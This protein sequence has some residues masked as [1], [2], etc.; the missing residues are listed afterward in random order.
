ME[1]IIIVMLLGASLVALLLV[2]FARREAAAERESAHREAE[3][4]RSEARAAIADAARREQQVVER[5]KEIAADHRNAQAYA[6]GLDERVEVIAR[7]EK[8]LMR[9]RSALDAERNR[10]R[11]EHAQEMAQLTETDPEALR[12]ELRAQLL[13]QARD[14]AQTELRRLERKSESEATSR[15][16]EIL[17]DAMQRQ[18]GETTTH[19]TTTWI[20]LPNEEMKG[21]IIGREGRNIRAF[22]SLTGVNLILEENVEAVQLSSFDVQRREIAEVALRA[23]IEDG[24]IQPQRIEAA[25]SR[26]LVGS[27]QRHRQAGLDALDEAGVKGLPMP[28]VD[29]LGRLRLRT[30]FGQTILGHLVESAQLAATLAAQVGADV[31][32]ARRAAFLH[33]IGKAFTPERKGPHAQIGAEFLAEHGEDAMV[34]NAVAAHHDEVPQ[35]TLEGVIV[36]IADSLSAARPG[37]RREDLDSYVQ[38]MESLEKIV[39]SHA[40]VAKAIAMSAGREMRVVVEPDEVDDEGARVLARTIAEHISKDLTFPGEIKVTVIRELRADA[41]AG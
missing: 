14:A 4:L 34:V 7:D 40:G 26:A 16:R 15:A 27:D 21:R 2:M 12:E 1:P 17:V 41:V 11:A 32:L 10:L 38:R 35:L 23:L 6:R 18:T 37:A 20:P 19:A 25:Y 30:S 9:D 22:E 39:G 8:R 31:E 29:T 28:V 5:E 3:S 13:E 33:D 36:Q 24:R